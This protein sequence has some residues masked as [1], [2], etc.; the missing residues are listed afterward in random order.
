MAVSSGLTPVITF[1]SITVTPHSSNAIDRLQPLTFIQW[2]SYNN[3][4]FTTSEESLI[5][6]QAYINKWHTVTNSAID[7]HTDAIQTLY[8]NL[9]KEITLN[10]TTVDEQRYLKNLNYNDPIDLAVAVPFFAKKIKDICLY[11]STLRDD[12]QTA[13]LQY[14]LKGSNVGIENLLY[15]TVS[16]ALNAEDIT[17]LYKTLTIS[18]SDI[19]NNMVID[20]EDIYDL[21][22]DY[23]DNSPTLPASAYN[24]TSGLRNEYFAANQVNIDP[25]QTLDFNQSIVSAIL[26]YPFYLL[27]IGEQ[28]TINPAV[29]ASQLNLLKDSDFITG[30][31][32]GKTSDLNLQYEGLEQ[33]KYIGSDFYYVITD[34]TLTSYTSGVLFN[35]DSEF[36]NVLNK[37]YPT[38][39]A[40]PSQEFL[41]TGKQL[42]L[43]FKPD[44]IGL[45]HFTNF[46]FTATVNLN[47]LQPN[48]VYYFPDPSKYGNISGN[49]KQTFITPLK[50]IE[51]NYFNKVDFS[52]QYKA[53]EVDTSPYYQLYRAYQSREQTLNYTDTGI[54]RY[55]DLQDFF[56]GE[57][58]LIWGNQDVYP[59]TPQGTF[60]IDERA[61]ELY[62]S[63]KT[64]VQYK[65]DIYGNEFGLY[66]DGYPIKAPSNTP[67]VQATFIDLIID[68][69]VFYDPV[70]G[71]NFDYSTTNVGP[72]Q[73]I[74]IKN[75][76]TYP[77]KNYSGVILNT[78]GSF[79]S[80]LT[81]SQLSTYNLTHNG[82]NAQPAPTTTTNGFLLTGIQP[83]I[84]PYGFAPEVFASDY[85]NMQFNCIT[86]DAQ[87][88][89][90]PNGNLLPD[91]G[92]SLPG[93]SPSNPNLYYNELADGGFSPSNPE[94]I[95]DFTN[96]P[97]FSF[98]PPLSVLTDYDCNFFLVDYYASGETVILNSEPCG[99]QTFFA[100]YTEPSNFVNVR[101]PNKTTTLD[102]TLTGTRITKPLYQTRSVDYGDLYFRNSSSSI[103]LPLSSALSATFL[104]FGSTVTS[105]ITSSQIINFDVYYD[106]LQ[107]ETENY[108]LFDK[109]YY[110]YNT[111]SIVENAITYGVIS[112]DHPE[113]S[114]FEKFST[115]WFNEH[116][117]QLIACKTTLFYDQSATNGKIIYPKIYLIDLKNLQPIQLYPLTHDVDLT[118]DLLKTFSLS[119]TSLSGLNVVEIEKPLLNYNEDTNTYILSYLAKDTA[120]AFYIVNIKFQYYNERL[121]L[122]STTIFK[123]TQD[124]L[125]ENFGDPITLPSFNTYNGILGTGVG[126]IDTDDNTFTFGVSS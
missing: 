10:Y 68:G 63:N 118:F 83:V 75:P 42:G 80:T 12:A 95:A 4:T 71:Y 107:I 81:P 9:I 46:K 18:L 33:S 76:Y 55:V 77:D 116:S 61:K 125:Q 7:V 106:V 104:K 105:E 11:Y 1:D 96:S 84:Y 122:L 26:K 36:A 69:Y 110:D 50:F 88:F 57:E 30:I 98:L 93:Y 41:K 39:A 22:P 64:L 45:L 90:S 37:R 48:T 60:P 87:T 102:F 91:Y 2:L 3:Q 108:L 21:Y 103:I 123:P 27:E 74:T 29:N 101:V 13:T 35:A 44:K 99:N 73:N 70:L 16:R 72:Y 97:S 49:T 121:D 20:V 58:K 25:F 32:T 67:A 47:Q 5:R 82:I 114:S 53:G 100:G 38:I 34:S 52:N 31:N 92:S 113:Q 19:R 6:Y 109:L 62:V 111:N 23:Y 78:N 115:V 89:I 56:S 86:K 117:K 8:V 112:R 43:F 126:Y 24:V 119:G 15:N 120:S 40:I 59:V 124:I 51:E 66:K 14:N 17:E 65:N 54:S 85:V 79:G 94:Y 28:I